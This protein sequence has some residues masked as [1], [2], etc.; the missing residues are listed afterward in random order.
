MRD[1]LLEYAGGDEKFAAWLKKVDSAI[2]RTVGLNLLDLP[3]FPYRDE[4]DAGADPREVAA[5]VLEEF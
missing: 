1:E 4:F 2:S 5:R 3:D